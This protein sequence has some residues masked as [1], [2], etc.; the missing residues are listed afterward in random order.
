MS[1][2]AKEKGKKKQQ[3]TGYTTVVH[4]YNAHVLYILRCQNPVPIFGLI[5]RKDID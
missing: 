1:E 5:C 3:K 4:M 2:R